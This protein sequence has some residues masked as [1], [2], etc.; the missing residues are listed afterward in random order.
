M[1][2]VQARIV[3]QASTAL[4]FKAKT[5]SKGGDDGDEALC[6]ACNDCRHPVKHPQGVAPLPLVLIEFVDAAL[7]RTCGLRVG[8]EDGL[9]K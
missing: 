7:A 6:S 1:Q 4:R 5:T 3:A 8:V 9:G 2:F